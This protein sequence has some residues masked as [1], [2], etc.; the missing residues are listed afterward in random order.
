MQTVTLNMT[1]LSTGQ[2]IERTID[3]TNAY[4]SG[5]VCWELKGETEQRK[6]LNRWINER[7]NE[8]H[9]TILDLNFWVFNK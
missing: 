3:A 9:N 5:S 1:D 8:Q 2:I 4:S 7:G 6:N